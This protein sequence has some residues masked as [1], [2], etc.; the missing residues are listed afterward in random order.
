V[1]RFINV[2]QLQQRLAQ[3]SAL[4]TKRLVDV[5]ATQ[6]LGRSVRRDQ[7]TYQLVQQRCAGR[8]TQQQWQSLEPMRR[9][10]ETGFAP[11]TPPLQSPPS[12]PA[13][14]L[15]TVDDNERPVVP[16]RRSGTRH[17]QAALSIAQVEPHDVS[18]GTLARGQQRR[19]ERRLARP[20][21]PDNLASPA[22]VRQSIDQFWQ[23]ISGGKDKVD[24]SGTNVPGRKRIGAARA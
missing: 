2:I 1:P 22:V 21:R 8:R 3:V 20:V 15:V 5:R 23:C 17:G 11:P 9:D 7:A 12:Q 24:R 6:P 10:Q 18:S 13:Q 19:Q 4:V 16:R 14:L